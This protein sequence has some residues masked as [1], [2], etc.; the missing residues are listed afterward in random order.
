MKMIMRCMQEYCSQNNSSCQEVSTQ[1]QIAAQ[2]FR[3][4]QANYKIVGKETEVIK[5][6]KLLQQLTPH[7]D[8]TCPY[9]RE[10]GYSCD[11]YQRET[12]E[13]CLKE[14]IDHL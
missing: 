1:Y 9:C 3:H 2:I 11:D 7:T 14:D 8:Q 10:L 5:N 12:L 6:E 13:N 4:L